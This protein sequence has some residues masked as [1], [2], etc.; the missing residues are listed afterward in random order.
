MLLFY[1]FGISSLEK[2][3]STSI[4]RFDKNMFF[5]NWEWSDT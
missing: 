3:A 2:Y 5:P 4:V 1:S